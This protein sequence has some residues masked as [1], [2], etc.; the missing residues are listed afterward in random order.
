MEEGAR[1]TAM[2]GA[3]IA[4]SDDATAIFWNPAG[5]GRED[6]IRIT[7]MKTRLFSVKGLS[8]DCVA[9]SLGRWRGLGFGFGWTRTA[10]KD[11]YSENAFLIG[12]GWRTPLRNLYFGSALRI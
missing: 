10:L 8:E 3:F 2:G 5:L 12:T 1:A 6:N 7:A 9:A 11:I 4:V